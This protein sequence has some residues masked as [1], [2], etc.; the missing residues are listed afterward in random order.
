MQCKIDDQADC[1]K[2]QLRISSM[3]NHHNGIAEK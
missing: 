2:L 1:K 3:I